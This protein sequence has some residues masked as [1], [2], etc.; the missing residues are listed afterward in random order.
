M[1]KRSV[2]G[3]T[4]DHADEEVDSEAD[5]DDDSNVPISQRKRKAP[6]NEPTFTETGR[7]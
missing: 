1:T 2:V 3:C 6:D 4:G 5:S 7:R